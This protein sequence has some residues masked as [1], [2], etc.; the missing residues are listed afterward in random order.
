MNQ[1]RELMIESDDTEV[2][3]ERYRYTA[4]NRAQYADYVRRALEEY[5]NDDSGMHMPSEGAFMRFRKAIAL[6]DLGVEPEDM[7]DGLLVEGKAIIAIRSPKYRYAEDP[8]YRW[9]WYSSLP[10]LLEQLRAHATERPK[11]GLDATDP[12]IKNRVGKM[13]DAALAKDITEARRKFVISLQAFWH[14]R[15]FLSCR[16][17]DALRTTFPNLD[18]PG[19]TQPTRRLSPKERPQKKQ[20]KQASAKQRKQNV[21]ERQTKQPKPDSSTVH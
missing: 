13:F 6:I 2:P 7:P 19:E 20:G 1:G 5:A 15:G 9:Y 10:A 3:M 17:V 11:T 16:Q 8:Q 14:E 21:I 18:I 4:E 12:E